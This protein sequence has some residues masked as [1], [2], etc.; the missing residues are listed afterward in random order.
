MIA[1]RYNKKDA[2]HWDELIDDSRN[3]TFL[4]KRSYM[5]YH[6]SR[7]DDFSLMIF[8]V[9]N[10]LQAVF[11]ANKKG[12]TVITHEGLTYGGLV[13][14]KKLRYDDVKECFNVLLNYYYKNNIEEIIYKAI[15]AFYHNKL[16]NDD[17]Y[18]L[19]QLAAKNLRTDMGWVIDNSHENRLQTRRKRTIKKAAQLKPEILNDEISFEP[20]WNEILIPNLKERFNVSPVHSLEEILHLKSCNTSNIEQFLVK[21]ENQVVAGATIFIYKN[22]VHA[23]YMSANILGKKYGALDYLMSYLINEKYKA[24]TFFSFGIVNEEGGQII[25]KGLMEWKESFGA[26]IHPN[27][28]FTLKTSNSKLLDKVYK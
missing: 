11:P 17:I 25:N 23:Q 12:N 22:V 16:F 13:V 1:L 26:I 8:D 18:I 24:K 28:F 27:Y 10:N 15:P 5:D 4:L 14:S 9:K 19:K 7:F 6:S 20:F 2:M 21:I 3:G